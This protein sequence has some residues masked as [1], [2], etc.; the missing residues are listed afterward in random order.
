MSHLASDTKLERLEEGRYQGQVSDAWN[1]GDN[2]NGGYLLSIVL[3][4]LR[5]SLPHPDPISITTH[6]LRPGSSNAPCE[7]VVDVLRTGRSLSTARATLTQE[8]KTRLEVLASFADVTVGA[9]AETK[10]TLPRPPLPALEDC[11]ARS[12]DAQGVSLPISQRLDVRLHPDLAEP[13]KAGRAEISGYIRLV[14]GA[15]PDS[16]TLCLF[17]DSFPPS[18]FALL[19]VV[20]WVPTIELTVHVRARPQPGWVYGQFKCKDLSGGRMI[21]D[22]ALWDSGGNLVARSRQ[23]GLVLSGP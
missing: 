12:G 14:D 15:E 16:S 21:E 19:G 3:S 11:I 5:A 23:I 20:G 22:G 18:P 13:G 1:I 8:G 9:G 7:V 4:A 17:A 10:L 2:P 6:Y